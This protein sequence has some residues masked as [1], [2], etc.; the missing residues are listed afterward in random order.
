MTVCFLSLLLFATP[1]R[2]RAVNEKKKKTRE[3][4]RERNARR[5]AEKS[6]TG[7][8]RTEREGRMRRGD[9]ESIQN[10]EEEQA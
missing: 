8:I 9:R 5:E 7:Q 4:G 6:R 10:G 3:R 1:S 2:R